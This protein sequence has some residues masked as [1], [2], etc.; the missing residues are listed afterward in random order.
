MARRFLV[1]GTLLMAL[2]SLDACS[3]TTV[4][5]DATSDGGVTDAAIL[6]SGI[7]IED[8]EPAEVTPDIASDVI[9]P[10]DV[11]AD[12]APDAAAPEDVVP[13]VPSLPDPD[14]EPLFAN[15]SEPGGDRNIYDLQDPQCPDHITPEPTGQ[16]GVDIILLDVIVTGLYGD[17][18]FVGHAAGGPYS[19]VAVFTHG[20]PHTDLSIGT[21]IEL[22]G[23]YAEYYE[24]TQIYAE[25]WT[26]LGEG[27][28]PAP[29]IPTHPHH[30]STNGIIAEMFEGVLVRV[31]NIETTHTI[32]DCP[33]DYGEFEITGSLRVDDM[34][35]KWNARLGDKF[36]AITGILHYSFGNFKIEPQSEADID[37]A[38]KGGENAISKC[39]ADECQATEA[40]PSS[41]IVV[42]SE[43]MAD[44]KGSDYGQEWVE[45]HNPGNESVSLDGWEIRDC[46]AQAYPLVGANLVIQPG[47]FLLL[48]ANKN[49]QTNGGVPVNYPYGEGFYLPNTVGSVLIY[50]APEPFGKLVDQMRY[51]RFDPWDVFHTGASLE[52]I[53]PTGDGTSHTNWKAGTQEYGNGPD[54]NKGTPG[55]KNSATP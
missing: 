2:F 52:R 49:P 3:E 54:F 41:Q 33:Q 47:G 15:C 13:D 32:P 50:D 8:T 27:V 7:A 4:T 29:Y 51:S 31:E 44:P 37:W 30:L 20:I 11:V 48:G 42:V 28:A 55:S 34:A 23:N 53:N 25:S 40:A 5:G 9:A 19:G 35:F 22:H 45:L 24:C 38:E 6:D 46:G 18:M 16:N 26:V 12:T 39:L 36:N 10:E 1:L 17:T 43:I 21:R 14:V